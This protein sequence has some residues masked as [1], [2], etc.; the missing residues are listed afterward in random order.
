MRTEAQLM[1]KF[2]SKNYFDMYQPCHNV[3]LQLH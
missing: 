1:N 2:N 3:D